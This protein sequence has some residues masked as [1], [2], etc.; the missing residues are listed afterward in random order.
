MLISNL[1]YTFVRVSFVC[2][3]LALEFLHSKGVAHQ[4]IQPHHLMLDASGRLKLIDFNSSVMVPQPTSPRGT[5]SQLN[6]RDSPVQNVRPCSCSAQEMV[7]LSP[8][9]LTA[10]GVETSG[11]KADWWSAGVV[12]HELLLGATPWEEWRVQHAGGIKQESAKLLGKDHEAKVWEGVQLLEHIDAVL[13]RSSGELPDE[14]FTFGKVSASAENICRG[15]LTRHIALRLGASQLGAI[16]L[17]SHPWFRRI[18]VS[19]AELE[20]GEGWSEG[21]NEWWESA[22][23][24][25]DETAGSVVGESTAESLRVRL[26]AFLLSHDASKLFES[27]DPTD[28]EL[29]ELLGEMDEEAVQEMLVETYGKGMRE[30]QETQSRLEPE[31]EAE[32]DPQKKGMFGSLMGRAGAVASAG[33][34]AT[35]DNAQKQTKE[36]DG[37]VR[38]ER[39][40]QE[41][42]Q[43]EQ[44]AEG[45]QEEEQDTAGDGSIIPVA[46]S[47]ASESPSTEEAKRRAKGAMAQVRQKLEGQAVE[48]K[49]AKRQQR[50]RANSSTSE[51]SA[52]QEQTTLRVTANYLGAQL[53][54]EKGKVTECEKQLAAGEGKISD[55][56]RQLA[57]QALE[58]AQSAARAQEFE[59]L[60]A[61]Q[62]ETVKSALFEQ[63]EQATRQRLMLQELE[64]GEAEREANRAV[65]EKRMRE[66][67]ELLTNTI[68]NKDKELALS[69]EVRVQLELELEELRELEGARSL[70]GD[71]DVSAQSEAYKRKMAEREVK[72]I[73][74]VNERLQQKVGV[75][76]QA[77]ARASERMTRMSLD[78]GKVVALRDSVDSLKHKLQ[79]ETKAKDRAE[80]K[81]R[82]SQLQSDRQ[83]E[84]AAQHAK[85]AYEAAWRAATEKMQIAKERELDELR[86]ELA[87]LSRS[88]DHAP[89][90]GG[91]TANTDAATLLLSRSP[92]QHQPRQT[93]ISPPSSV[94]SFSSSSSPS[95][96][97]ASTARVDFAPSTKRSAIDAGDELQWKQRVADLKQKLRLKE[98]LEQRARKSSQHWL[99]KTNQVEQA[100][101]RMRE[102]MK[103][104]TEAQEKQLRQLR[105][106]HMKEIR[107]A[108]EGQE[109]KYR[110]LD[111]AHKKSK[112]DHEQKLAESIEVHKKEVEAKAEECAEKI[113]VFKKEEAVKLAGCTRVIEQQKQEFAEALE[114]KKAAYAEEIQERKQEYEISCNTQVLEHKEILED[115]EAGM[116]RAL[117][118]KDQVHAS[119]LA[120]AMVQAIERRD[121]QHAAV[122][123]Q[124]AVANSAAVETAVSNAVAAKEV[125]HAT[126]LEQVHIKRISAL[127]AVEAQHAEALAEHGLT[128]ERMAQQHAEALAAV[129][130]EHSEVVEQREAESTAM[131]S[132]VAE[133]LAVVERAGEQHKEELIEAKAGHTETLEQVYGEHGQALE[134]VREE[135]NKALEKVR[136]VHKE[137]MKRTKELHVKAAADEMAKVLGETVWTKE[138]QHRQALEEA[139]ESK[140][141][142]QQEI[143]T[144]KEQHQAAVLAR[145][146]QTVQEQHAA[147]LQAKQVQHASTL[148]QALISQQEQHTEAITRCNRYAQVMGEKLQSEDKQHEEALAAQVEQFEMVLAAKDEEHAAAMACAIQEEEEQFAQA[149]SQALHSKQAEHA[150]AVRL[151]QAL[152]SALERS[153]PS[154]LEQE[155]GEEADGGNEGGGDAES[156][157]LWC[158]TPAAVNML[159]DYLKEGSIGSSSEISSP[160]ISSEGSSMKSPIH[161]AQQHISHNNNWR[162]GG[163]DNNA[164]SDRFATMKGERKVAELEA[165]LRRLERQQQEQ[166]REQKEQQWQAE[167]RHTEM[168]RV[169]S[170]EHE[171]A[172]QAALMEHEEEIEARLVNAVHEQESALEEN[173]EARLAT[174][175]Q[176]H[177]EQLESA[178]HVALTAQREQAED[179]HK[180][181]V[182]QA[183]GAMQERERE[184]HGLEMRQLLHEAAEER[185]HALETQEANL[186]GTSSHGLGGSS[187][188]RYT[189]QQPMQGARPEVEV[190]VEFGGQFRDAMVGM[191]QKLNE[192]IVSDDDAVVQQTSAQSQ[193]QLLEQQL[194]Q[195][196]QEEDEAMAQT[197]QQL[198]EQQDEPYHP[199]QRHYRD[200]DHV[201]PSPDLSISSHSSNSLLRTI[202]HLS[203]RP[204]LHSD[205][206]KS[207]LSPKGGYQGGYN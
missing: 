141:Q 107:V 63:N 105:T 68:V 33:Y 65:E 175:E 101:E 184:A 193:Q 197:R 1:G 104:A 78:S 69:V 39:W 167:A 119:A 156:Q 20:R 38:R 147:A 32:A 80:K 25:Y 170:M 85:S 37:E 149:M 17:K 183:V 44:E 9:V 199:Q 22:R 41:G 12:L 90:L 72:A 142:Q 134:R 18:G 188:A 181:M 36:E 29:E 108:M 191:M 27:A 195:M 121:E 186:A 132:K 52:S 124:T 145:A 19:W 35:S 103:T 42:Q 110:R 75:L 45:R 113:A 74:E 166:Q 6:Q 31:A 91:L 106:E 200:D 173:L 178:L 169:K 126:L 139:I 5:P 84:E 30:A 26:K 8:E 120:H 2:A 154:D 111:T 174:E 99:N 58:M 24:T 95:S 129:E 14:P 83:K 151:E 79:K 136:G 144:L 116:H 207:N 128:V 138:Q 131:E 7:Y 67:M 34:N 88:I 15:L 59:T 122:V 4:S 61:Q 21:M 163:F 150:Q 194:A 157:A 123:A 137:H 203:W 49:Q 192:S 13:K 112:V 172:L 102:K 117:Q 187:A 64:H 159:E 152:Q 114:Q 96:S 168:L 165:S 51:E 86:Q 196:V 56:E 60:L 125:E 97:V 55:Y 82:E 47:L 130:A 205:I 115:K 179:R 180:N 204:D 48:V 190:G 100:I 46:P 76:E 177:L 160:D 143:L 73:E 164:P 23:Q 202:S 11:T 201:P 71:V 158:S 133:A 89:P 161:H 92:E 62:A 148:K 109:K 182:S 16:E 140:V 57:E 153:V 127:E 198:Y 50:S 176:K 40:G 189:T 10:S 70:R 77:A 98:D 171:Q 28:A 53:T 206:T 185:K 87:Q 94:S 54:V 135:H 66:E 162:A 81:L 146:I 43:A 155:V 118:G 3:A 93:L